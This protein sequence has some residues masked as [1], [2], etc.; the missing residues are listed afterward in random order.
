M[1]RMKESP[2]NDWHSLVNAI[3]YENFADT[4][5]MY[6]ELSRVLLNF[7]RPNE[8][9]GSFCDLG[10]GTGVSTS[11][12]VS[13]MGP[14][15]VIYGFDKSEAMLAIASKNKNLRTVRFI[16]SPP[17]SFTKFDFLFSSAAFWQFE[18]SLQST[19]CNQNLSPN[20]VLAF[21]CPFELYENENYRYLFDLDD[22]R[23]NICDN[24]IDIKH[25]FFTYHGSHDE[26]LAFLEIPVFGNNASKQTF[27]RCSTFSARWVLTVVR[28]SCKRLQ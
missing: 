2:D 17:C 10:C 15:K 22:F 5:P 24:A 4:F 19:W 3:A 18:R 27:Q 9:M 6:R 8:T 12:L 28:R 14:N 25:S 7:A 20:G 11:A 16:N 1:H 21:N 26:A 23:R 13:H